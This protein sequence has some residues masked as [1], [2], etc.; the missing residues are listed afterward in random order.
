MGEV[1]NLRLARKAK[2]RDDADKQAT[3]NRAAFGRSKGEKKKI[4]SENALEQKRL[5]GHHLKSPPPCGES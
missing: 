1:I 5:D 4:A 3:E 2:A